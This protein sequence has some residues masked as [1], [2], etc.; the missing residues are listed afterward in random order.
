MLSRKDHKEKEKRL[1][2]ALSK[3]EAAKKKKGKK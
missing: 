1:A 3:V 2:A